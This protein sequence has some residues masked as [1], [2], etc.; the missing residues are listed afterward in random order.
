MEEEQTKQNEKMEVESV[1]DLEDISEN[2]ST[3]T[4]EN[5]ESQQAES[6]QDSTEVNFDPKKLKNIVEAALLASGQTLSLDQIQCLFEEDARPGKPFIREV[7]EQ[8]SDDYI[9]RGFELKEVAS[10]YRIQVRMEMQPWISRL[11]EE[12]PPKYSRAFLETLAI[13]A[14]RQPITRGEIEDIRG[15]SVSSQI[16]KSLQERGW[17][18]VV[19]KRDVPGHP[20][21]YGT[22]KEFLSYFNLKSLDQ[23]PSLMELRD[24]TEINAELDLQFPDAIQ[25]NMPDTSDDDEVEDDSTSEV[26]PSEEN[27]SEEAKREEARSEEAR[28]EETGEE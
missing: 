7:L 1:D 13:I 28:R 5:S 8:L 16:M 9:G 21:I 3:E 18:R 27:T 19:G 4:V 2:E 14:Y 26:E 12:K 10:G 20:T 24:I 15:V 23:L 17:I 25:E 11:W 22:T 6:Q